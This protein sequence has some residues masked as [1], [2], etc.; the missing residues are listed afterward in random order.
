MAHTDDNPCLSCGACCAHFRVSFYCGEL[1]GGSGGFVP[2]ELTSQ[3]TPVLACMKGTEQGGQRCIALGG[4]L[5]QPGIH[6]TIYE[7]RP[8]PCREFSMWRDDGSPNP[9][10]NRL[11]VKLGLPELTHRTR[12]AS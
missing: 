5:G 7:N 1:T 8:T 11:R 3:V 9:D 6:C 10:C 12:P 2:V 4:T